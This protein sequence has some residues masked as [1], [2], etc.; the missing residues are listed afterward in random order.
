VRDC[1]KHM[2][3]VK[4][5]QLYTPR[6]VHLAVVRAHQYNCAQQGVSSAMLV[7]RQLT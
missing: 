1:L 7:A 5:T 3:W 4:L 6:M 2:P